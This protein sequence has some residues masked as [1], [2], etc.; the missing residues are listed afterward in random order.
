MPRRALASQRVTP[1]SSRLDAQRRAAIAVLVFVAAVGSLGMGIW[2]FGGQGGSAQVISSVNAG[3]EALERARG[4]LD[5]VFGTTPAAGINLVK[6]DP[7]KAL[8]LLTDAHEQLAAAETYG[9]PTSVTSPLRLRAIAGLDA[10]YEMTDVRDSVIFTL[11]ENDPPFDLREMVKGPDGAPYILDAGT[12]SVYRIDLAERT[13]T[14]VMREGQKVPGGSDAAA[15]KLIATGGP[16]L[17]V[18]DEGNT[19]WRWRPA[20]DK[21]AGTLSRIKVN[22]AASWGEDISG[23]GTYV[24]NAAA[25]LYNL[26]VIDPSE[27]QILAY[28]PAADGSGYPAAPT[29]RLATAR[30]VDGMRQLV[31]D[32]DIFTIDA[33]VITRIVS[34]KTEG[35]DVEAPGDE[36]LRDAPVYGLIATGSDRR[37]GRLYGWDRLNRRF[38]AFDK[39]DGRFRAQYRLGGDPSTWSDVR[40]FYILPGISDGPDTMIWIS[41]KAIHQVVLEAALAGAT[42]SIPA[43]PAP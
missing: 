10:L 1:A 38:I 29:G 9:V 3:L 40:G 15:P 24:R 7:P 5:K 21:G 2:L 42:P 25:G 27:Q 6:D 14:V 18:L 33:G 37:T 23:L 34:G 35:W 28:A 13:A 19:L 43:S 20:D 39:V 11:P 30:P 16:D 26:Y 31:I 32:G 41:A 8:Q 12:N 22:G 36:L 17:L 4:D